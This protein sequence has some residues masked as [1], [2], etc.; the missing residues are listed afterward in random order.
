M[1]ATGCLM[2]AGNRKW[3]IGNCVLKQGKEFG[4]SP[5]GVRGEKLG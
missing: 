3:E 4:G 5:L 2:L 1:L